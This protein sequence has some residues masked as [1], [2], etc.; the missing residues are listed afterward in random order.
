MADSTSELRTIL[1]AVEKRHNIIQYIQVDFKQMCDT[2]KLWNQIIIISSGRAPS[3]WITTLKILAG[4][5][6]THDCEWLVSNG[7][8]TYSFRTY[9]YECTTHSWNQFEI[10]IVDTRRWWHHHLVVFWELIVNR[11]L[12]LLLCQHYF[13]LMVW[14]LYPVDFSQSKILWVSVSLKLA[15]H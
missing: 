8:Q 2:F 14:K 10:N 5:Y 11:D 6:I 13:F 4:K 15:L 1:F 12:F 7:I 9:I 3:H